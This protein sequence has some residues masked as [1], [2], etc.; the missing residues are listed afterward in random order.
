MLVNGDDGAMLDHHLI[1]VIVSLSII[2]VLEGEDV[3]TEH[4]QTRGLVCSANDL[5]VFTNLSDQLLWVFLIPLGPVL[6]VEV[7]II[8]NLPSILKV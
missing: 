6:L 5:K 3:L 8:L 1:C 4:I 7:I 2:L